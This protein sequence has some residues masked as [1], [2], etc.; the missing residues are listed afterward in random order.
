[1]RGF[2]IELG[3][4]EAA[5]G[6][7]PAVRQAVVL[8][9]E[10]V[11]GDRRLVAYVVTDELGP[12]LPGELRERLRD[13]LPEYM[14]PAGSSRSATLPLTPNGKVD[15]R[16]LPAPPASRGERG[17]TGSPRH[18]PSWRWRRCGPRS[19]AS[20]PWASTTTSSTW[21][22]TRSSPRA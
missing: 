15:R 16:A 3:E 2:R 4:I 7:H 1:M 11:P 22:G 21:A 19:S 14:V 12:E 20:T 8:A 9:R 18:P 13:R 17:P 6:E 10:D 5:L